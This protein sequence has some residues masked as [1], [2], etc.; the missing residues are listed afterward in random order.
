MTKFAHIKD[1]AIYRIINLTDDEVAAIP[2]HKAAYLLPYVE[3]ARPT[4]DTATHHA[5]VR[6]SDD[7][8]PTL[9]TQAWAGAVAKTQ[10]ELD[11]ESEAKIDRVDMLAFK[12]LLNHENR[13]RALEGKQAVTANQFRSALKA[14]L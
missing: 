12:V 3:V 9:V 8:Q 6:L 4:Y 14:M 11:A 10:E 2:P 13:A 7:I 1:G 5:P